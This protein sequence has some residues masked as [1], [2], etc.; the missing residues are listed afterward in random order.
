VQLIVLSVICVSQTGNIELISR[1]LLDGTKLDIGLS[2]YL[3]DMGFLLLVRSQRRLQYNPIIPHHCADIALLGYHNC[4]L[5]SAITN[6]SM[7]PS[8]YSLLRQIL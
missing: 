8:D 6:S 2:K 7:I 5:E 1:L 4:C 3:S